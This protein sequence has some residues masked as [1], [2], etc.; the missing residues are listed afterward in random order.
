MELHLHSYFPFVCLPDVPARRWYAAW[1]KLGGQCCS[2]KLLLADASARFGQFH[3]VRLAL[4]GRAGVYGLAAK[5]LLLRAI[6]SRG[7]RIL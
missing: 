6:R 7:D 5:I 2:E 4:R 1:C 3:E